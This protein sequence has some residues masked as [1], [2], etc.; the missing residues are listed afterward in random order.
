MTLTSSTTALGGS[1]QQV[2]KRMTG[3]DALMDAL[4]RNGVE[5]IFGYPGG[6]ILPIYDAVYKAEQQG[7]LKHI[8]VRHEQGGAHAADGY[9]RATGRVG[10]CFGTSGPGATNL[11]TGIATA[12]MDSVPM[13]VITGQVPRPCIG[14]D[15]FQETDIFGIT[16][17]IVKHSWVVRDPGDLAS[18]VAQAFF[19]AASGRPG[20]V[21]IDIP[22]DVGQ[23][24]FDYQPVEPGSVVPAGFH[25]FPAPELS[26]I[27]A[28]LDLIDDAQRPLLYVG[29]GVI[30]AGA[31]ES[32]KGF[33]ERHQ[34]PVTTTLMGKGAFDERHPLALGMLGMHGTAYAN[35]A[36]TECDLLIAVGARF[37][38]RVTGKLDTFAPRARVIH[39][40][41]DPAEVAKNRRPD[42]AVLGDVGVSLVKLLDLSKQKSVEL[43]TSAWLTRIESWKNLYPL[44]TPPE[45]GPIYPQEVLLAIRDLAPEAYITTDVGQHQMWAA[46]YLR[47]GPRQW[48]SSAGLGTMGFGMPAAIGVQ[49]ALPDEQV[50]CIAGDSSIL[51]NIQE[52]GTLIEY[53][54]PAKI[55]IVNNHWQ[56][57][58]RQWQQSFYEDRY[59][60]T[61][62]LPGM[63]DFVAL[64]KAFRVGG[65]L[66]TE[67]KDLR[68]SLKQALATPGPMLIDVHVRRD[69]N[70]YPMVPPGKS[71]AQ[72]VGLPNHPE[73]SGVSL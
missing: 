65:V 24:E 35:F 20:P 69:E 11:V 31:H 19:I 14:T 8:L 16:L 60:A 9:A 42:V 52:L 5:I 26:S 2:Q 29:G 49:I 68:S 17:P 32:L 44:M 36:V 54:I 7:W 28:A 27:E 66:I 67:R 39:F 61:D 23:E 33:A 55:V 72:M 73:L 34:I 37:D 47:N 70:C 22:K 71:N 57:M 4:R 12:Q 59:S 46:Q 40:E 51:M 3:A 62:M 6:A 64:A 58:V 18:V 30:S 53:N 41:I 45:E 15:A 50:V 25:R 10:V 56:G 63:P 13:V 43:R 48:I 1:S 21:L 38:D